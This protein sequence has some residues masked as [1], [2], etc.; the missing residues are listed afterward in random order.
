MSNMCQI[1]VKYMPYFLVATVGYR[2]YKYMCDIIYRIDY[3]LITTRTIR[4]TSTSM[5]IAEWMATAQK[6][7]LI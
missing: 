5:S 7:R 2:P 1:H 6:R 3:R 4:C